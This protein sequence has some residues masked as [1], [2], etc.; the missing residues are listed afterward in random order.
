MKK[1]ILTGIKI[2]AAVALAAGIA[3]YFCFTPV[4][5]ADEDRSDLMR[6]GTY[7]E[8]LK[9]WGEDIG[10]MTYAQAKELLLK[11]EQEYKSSI[12]FTL[13]GGGNTFVIGADELDIR[14]NTDSVL[15]EALFLAKEGTLNERRAEQERIKTADLEITCT[16]NPVTAA[17]RAVSAAKTLEKESS[18]AS[19][20]FIPKES[21]F[22][23][24][25]EVY[26]TT[27]DTEALCTA[28]VRQAET[29]E[30]SPIEIPLKE[31]APKV[32]EQMLRDVTVKRTAF[33]TSF[34][35]SPY[36]D[37]NRVHNIK[38][39]VEIINSSGK[40]T[41]K[42]GEE[43]SLNAVLGPRTASGGWKEA[44]G[45]VGGKTVDQPGGG[46][47]QIST[48]LYGA[49]LT[50]DLEVTDRINH[51]IPVGYSKKGMDATIST[52]G[53]DLKI[54]NST[55]SNIYLAARIADGTKV[56]FDI[57]GEP[58]SGFDGISLSSV[59]IKDI[60]PEAEMKITVDENYP[61]DYED[62]T[63][64]RRTGSFW[65]TYKVYKKDGEEILRKET[66]T[67]TYKAFAGEKTVGTQ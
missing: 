37:A 39:C 27:V 8:G 29:L 3:A 61:S 36:N 52:G 67:S 66:Y 58:F 7:A 50:A 47:C 43:L 4:A 38:K 64:K 49:A 19:L 40:T 24:T 13:T 62:I 17:G 25:P 44:P 32:T 51:S 22:V 42:P 30:F 26:G 35:D 33:F 20:E 60:A 45:Y 14:F 12:S 41:L 46:V 59:K 48:T 9:V 34:A 28:V 57:Y 55:G 63:V 56:Y 53:P 18:D 65:R 31:I 2:F 5:L 16:V 6:T 1:G 21:R 15:K 11:K 10:T 23:Y 54:K